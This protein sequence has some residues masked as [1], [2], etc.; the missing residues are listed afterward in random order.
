MTDNIH[1]IIL[2]NCFET[3]ATKKPA[4]FPNSNEILV[5]KRHISPRPTPEY[6]LRDMLHD[7]VFIYFNKE[8][9]IHSK[10]TILA[11]A[12]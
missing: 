5:L 8:K 11:T 7:M 2:R 9:Q 4:H 3:Y 10:I 1:Y 12:K 6:N